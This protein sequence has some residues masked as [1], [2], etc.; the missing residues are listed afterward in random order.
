MVFGDAEVEKGGLGVSYVQ[1]AVGL[2]WKPRNHAA[3][4]PAGFQVCLYHAPYEVGRGGRR[5]WA[6]GVGLL[7]G[8]ALNSLVKVLLHETI[9][10]HRLLH[11]PGAGHRFLSRLDWSWGLGQGTRGRIGR[12]SST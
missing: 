12:V 10:N 8:H 7:S 2:R 9:P 11:K 4:K 1:V 6:L 3:L 5:R